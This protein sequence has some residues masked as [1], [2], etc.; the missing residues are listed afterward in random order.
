MRTGRSLAKV[1]LRWTDADSGRTEEIEGDVSS[2]L[3]A[4]RFT[5]SSAEFQLVSAVGVYAEVLRASRW[6][7]GLDLEDVLNDV[8][9]LPWRELGDEAAQEFAELLEKAVDLD[10]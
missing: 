8:E 5:D 6:V 7:R 4:D 2:S 1:R 10:R 9:D 3:L